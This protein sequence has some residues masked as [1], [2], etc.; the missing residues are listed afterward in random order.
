MALK[1][2]CIVTDGSCACGGYSTTYRVVKS[3][4]CTPEM[5]VALRVHS[6]SIKNK[7]KY[8]QVN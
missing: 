8:L 5:N 7:I 4:R 3:L 2:H 6:I 1:Y